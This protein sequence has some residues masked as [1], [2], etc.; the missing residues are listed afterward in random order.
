MQRQMLKEHVHFLIFK[1]KKQKKTQMPC[2]ISPLT[3]LYT[4]IS[5]K[6]VYIKDSSMFV[7]CTENKPYKYI[8]VF[9]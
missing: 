9:Y 7:K 5:M 3:F 1:K 6:P 2:R 4:S 8:A